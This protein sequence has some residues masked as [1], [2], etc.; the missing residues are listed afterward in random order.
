MTIIVNSISGSYF[1]SEYVPDF[2][3]VGTLVA[4]HHGQLF[5]LSTEGAEQRVLAAPSMP[6]LR[7]YI[8]LRS[9]ENA[10]TLELVSPTGF[11]LEAEAE[12]TAT[13]DAEGETITLVSVPSDVVEDGF[14]WMLLSNPWPIEFASQEE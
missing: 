2:G 1:A 7:I 11:G 8:R 13:F 14:R 10:G 6:N 3:P 12:D 9:I 5:E 4:E